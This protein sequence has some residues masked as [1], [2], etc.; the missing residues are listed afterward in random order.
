MGRRVQA[1]VSAPR[2]DQ[3]QVQIFTPSCALSGCHAGASPQEGMD[4]SDGQ[5]YLNI[6]NVASNQVPSLDRIE[7]NQPNMSYLIQ[8]V[9]GTAAEGAQ[10]PF[11]GAA[12]SNELMQVL[13]DWVDDGAQN[14]FNP[15]PAP[16]LGY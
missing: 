7:P 5:A 3:V 12:L 9:E 4:L 16:D 13:R 2:F 11:G 6:V 15:N 14:N 10:M 8:K 1:A